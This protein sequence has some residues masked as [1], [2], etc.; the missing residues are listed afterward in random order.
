MNSKTR[1]EPVL[2]IMAAGMGSRYGGLKQMDPISGNGE[3]ILDFSLY[4]A[5]IAG[6]KKVIFVIKKEIEEDFKA[7]IEGKAS[8]HIDAAY[9]FQ[10]LNDIPNGFAVPDGRTKPWGTCHAVLACR[11]M[12]DGPFAVINADDYY[13]SGAFQMIYDC[14]SSLDDETDEQGN[15]TYNYAMVNY[16]IENTLTENGFVAR[17]VCEDDGNGYLKEINERTKIMQKGGIIV[18]AEEARDRDGNIIP[19]EKYTK[20]ER[21]TPVSMNFWGFTR[22][23][24]DELIERFPEFLEATLKTNPEKGEYYLPFAVQQLL[25]EG[26]AKVKM[27]ESHDKWYGV[28]YHEDKEDV[29][30]AMQSLKDKGFYPD[31]LWK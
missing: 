19:G 13:G 2:V 24:I 1:K 11:D 9:A 10:E 17:G 22:S 14:L 6:F 31:K 16:R 28:T 20:V 21:G 27:L 25:K 8:K 15:V 18:Y 29:V 3:V 30:N 4:D 5:V 23:F 26:K 12:I 7:L